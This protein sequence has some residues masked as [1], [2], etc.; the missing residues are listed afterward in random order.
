MEQQ[1][2]ADPG[3]AQLSGPALLTRLRHRPLLI[4]RLAVATLG[5]LTLA[6]AWPD[7]LSDL[8]SRETA[9]RERLRTQALLR[10]RAAG[11]TIQAT[12]E[13]F[14]FALKITRA[15]VP[16]GLQAVASHSRMVVEAL[17]PELV[18]QQ[19]LIDAD[20]YLVYSSLGP[21][22]RN[23]LGDRN[24][25]RSLATDTGDILQVSPPVL[26]RLTGKWSIQIARAI[27][28]NGRFDGVVSLAVSP[29]AW[30][31]QLARFET[32]PR[33]TLTLVDGSG[34][35]LLRTLKGREHYGKQ[36]P[37]QRDYILHPERQ[38]GDYVAHASVDGVLRQ[39]AWTRLPSG[40][41]MLSGIALDEA[42]A[43]VHEINHWTL[44]RAGLSSALFALVVIILL[45]ALQRYEKAVHQLG[46]REEHYRGV[47]THMGEGIMVI[48][49][50]GLIVDTNPAFSVITGI[51][52]G[53]ARGLPVSAL[54]PA[55][56][57]ET[58]LAARLA[59]PRPG[60]WETDFPGVRKDG[61]GYTGH[62]MVSCVHDAHGR[63]THRIA[64]LTDVTE[65]R[66]RDSEIWHQA[67][68]DLLTGLPNRALMNDRIESLL[69]QARRNQGHVTVMFIDLDHFK[70]VNDLYGH[71][72]GDLLLG[73][74]GQRLATLFRG[75]DSVARL[76][77]DEFIVAMAAD[78]NPEA[79]AALAR[80]VLDSLSRP[81]T[82]TGRDLRISCSI[83]IAHF[84]GDGDSADTLI[85]R[86]DQA[87]YKAKGRG[88]AGWST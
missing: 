77:G 85:N 11:E 82:I 48:D 10:A 84:P 56:T 81:F 4:I 53:E 79:D 47:L 20:G 8:E 32:A 34:H 83:G 25:F 72:T 63:V 42:L 68:F 31:Q 12:I 22:P 28:R 39:Y 18:L 73:Q 1:H 21:S 16:D 5:I 24:Y 23:Y 43:P 51:P 49:R 75:D 88:R 37:Q 78:A 70:P 9:A 52:A 40:L 74:V 7:V 35:V 33:D 38:E 15:A 50:H 57:G 58:G 27:K 19:F 55:D 65:Q 62:A 71:D 45:L 59:L 36:A 44:L 87:M 41:V 29:D 2:T 46:V 64:L 61:Q 80:K 13:R 69:R 67:N 76:G 66:R 54:E 26:G 6:L 86:A 30:T 14:D 60:H 17:P 3:R